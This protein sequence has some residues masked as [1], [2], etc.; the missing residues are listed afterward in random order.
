MTGNGG[1]VSN[2][3]TLNIVAVNDAPDA[4]FD[5][6]QITTEGNNVLTGT[7]TST[8]IDTRDQAG[9]TASY[10]LL[11]ASIA[12]SDGNAIADPTTNEPVAVQGLTISAD[13][14][15][16]STPLIPPTTLWQKVRSKPS[17]STTKLRTLLASLMPAPSSSHSP[18]PT[19]LPLPPS[20]LLKQQQKMLNPSPV[21][22]PQ[23]MPTPK[24]PS[25]TASLVLTSLA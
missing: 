15:W 16:S 4:T 12:D 7:L 11:S 21:S 3:I 8:D 24:T 9:D 17:P 6:A 18:V 25:P 23:L 14:S 2:T 13:G 10:S 1:S 5:V 19:T 20:L 22:S